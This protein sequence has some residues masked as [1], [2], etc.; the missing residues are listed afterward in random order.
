MTGFNTLCFKRWK[1]LR[2][3]TYTG[4]TVIYEYILKTYSGFQ[5]RGAQ[6]FQ[7][8]RSYMKIPGTRRVTRIKFHTKDTHKNL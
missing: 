5:T 3:I 6:T 8:S 1:R 4:A 2:S 7:K